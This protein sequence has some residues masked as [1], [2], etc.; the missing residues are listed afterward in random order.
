MPTENFSIHELREPV[1]TGETRS[2][3]WRRNQ[4][5]TIDLI[6]DKHESEI[7]DALKTDLGKPETEAFFELIALKQEIKLAQKKLK[8]W[9]RYKPIDIPLYMQPG[10]AKIIPEPLGCVL[11]IGAWNYPFMLTIQPLISALAAGNTAVLKPSEFSQSTSNLIDSLF[12][13]YFP[14]NIVRVLQGDGD[15]SKKLIE[16][17]FDHIFFTGG[18]RVGSKVMEA[19][20]KHLTPVTLELG[21]KNP[22]I[23]LPGGD[24]DITAK[25][26]VWGRCLNSGQ[27]C[28]A[29]NHVFVEE[30]IRIPLIESMKKHILSFYG[31]DPV[32]SSQIG[33]MNYKQFEKVKHSIKNAKD[34]QRVIFGGETS[35]IDRKISPT[36][37]KLTD[38]NDPLLEEELFGPVLPILSINNLDD[39]LF[40][41]RS[42]EKPLAIYM[43]GGTEEDQKKLIENTSSGGVCFNDVVLHAGIPE[44]PFGGIGESGM[45]KYHGESGFQNFSHQRS[46]FSKPFWLDI[47]FRYPPYKIDLS[48]MKQLF[49]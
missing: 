33:K 36:L 49:R 27:T 28:L 11:I 32:R 17:R 24:I 6:I 12:S 39:A 26:L 8:F 16:N 13:K 38:L 37:I 42:Q 41:M 46:I 2:E 15:F 9:M 10:S 31:K 25:R 19:A 43:F 22:S 47:Q 34:N 5:K 4:L 20:A 23:V 48:I 40:H 21:G 29:P 14:K 1:L 45:G 7:I 3:S 35:D 44:L 18:S 30:S